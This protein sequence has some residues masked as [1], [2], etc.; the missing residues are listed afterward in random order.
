[1]GRRTQQSQWV[2]TTINDL[3]PRHPHDIGLTVREN[4]AALDPATLIAQTEARVGTD[5]QSIRLNGALVGGLVGLL[6]ALVHRVLG[7][8]PQQG[9]RREEKDASVLASSTAIIPVRNTPSNVPAPPIEATGVAN[10]VT[11]DE[12][13]HGSGHIRGQRR[14]VPRDC[15]GGGAP[16]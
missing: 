5:V 8:H 4:L 13:A 15:V 2:R 10:V 6:R 16:A 1:V 9:G 11:W 7:E 12:C 3:L 14:P